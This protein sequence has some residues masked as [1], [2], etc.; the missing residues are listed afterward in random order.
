MSYV[1]DTIPC[2][3]MSGFDDVP[4]AN[5]P[6]TRARVQLDADANVVGT[7][8]TENSA[9]CAYESEDEDI[10]EEQEVEDMTSLDNIIVDLGRY[11]RLVMCVSSR[12]LT[13]SP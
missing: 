9:L 7:K 12:S 2:S 4:P 6:L 10:L 3:V 1:P 5:V 13:S 8:N 11:V